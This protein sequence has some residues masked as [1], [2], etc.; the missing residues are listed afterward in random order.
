MLASFSIIWFTK[1]TKATAVTIP[2]GLLRWIGLA[3]VGFGQYEAAISTCDLP[4][5]EWTT[6]LCLSVAD[7]K[8][9]RHA[10]AQS[11]LNALKKNLR[12]YQGRS[13]KASS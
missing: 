8:L 13:A 6:I 7:D 5:P 12:R 1:K 4:N 11:A 9:G 2:T 3:H 10:D